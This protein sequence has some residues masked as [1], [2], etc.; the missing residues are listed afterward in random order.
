VTIP[1]VS[2]DRLVL[3]SASPRRRELLE[4][5]GVAFEVRP[6]DLDETPRAGEEPS[7]L[8]R[9][10]A[11]D[12]ARAVAADADGAWVLGADTVVDLD[13]VTFGKPADDVDA[14]RMLRTL[15]GRTHL[16]H[17][18]VAVCRPDGTLVTEVVTTSVTFAELSDEVIAWYVA[19]GEPA[20]KAGAY[21]L[22]G[23]GGALVERIDGSVSNVLGLP[24]TTVRRLL[25]P[26]V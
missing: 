21:G 5:I 1:H 10:L 3:A 20:D 2:A 18:G 8:A 14:G 16:V 25:A 11:A 7:T 24:L 12:K 6:A 23:I 15:A 9:R 19:T 17:T 26:V 22:Q 4:R 13:G